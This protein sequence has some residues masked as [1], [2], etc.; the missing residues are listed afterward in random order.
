[1]KEMDGVKG[2]V[3]MGVDTFEYEDMMMVGKKKR[4]KCLFS[5]RMRPDLTTVVL[6]GYA[7]LGI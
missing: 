7:H 6:D 4:T 2:E 1:M 3:G 5:L